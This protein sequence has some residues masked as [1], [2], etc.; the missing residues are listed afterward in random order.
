MKCFEITRKICRTL[1][2]MIMLG[3]P[4]WSSSQDPPLQCG[5]PFLVWEDLSSVHFSSVAQL[6]PTLYNP[7]NHST[8]GL[9]DLTCHKA[10]KPVSYEPQLLSLCP[11]AHLPQ[12]PSPWAEGTKPTCSRARAPQ[13]EKSLPREASVLQLESP[14]SPLSLTTESRTP[15]TAK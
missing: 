4:W 7:M 11:R 13:W 10:S 1:W 2:K 9:P 14:S 3:L 15:R 12:L 6:C 8:P 5:V